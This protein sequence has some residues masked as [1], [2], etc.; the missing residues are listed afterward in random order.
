LEVAKTKL[1]EEK[2][3]LLEAKETGREPPAGW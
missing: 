2:K 3:A 1:E